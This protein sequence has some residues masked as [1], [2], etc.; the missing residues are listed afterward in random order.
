MLK[1]SHNTAIIQLLSFVYISS[2]TCWFLPTNVDEYDYND[3]I[4]KISLFAVF[5]GF[6]SIFYSIFKFLQYLHVITVFAVVT[7]FISNK[8]GYIDISLMMT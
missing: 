7:V 6:Y 4:L 5:T 3:F 2:Y 1:D 8:T